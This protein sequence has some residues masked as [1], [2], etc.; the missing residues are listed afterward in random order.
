MALLN[1]GLFGVKKSFYPIFRH[2]FSTCSTYFRDF[3][4]ASRG[5]L[6]GIRVL[7]L[8]RVLG[9]QQKNVKRIN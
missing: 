8:T 3:V 4:P 9:T 7:D 2:S 5:P 1:T 6:E